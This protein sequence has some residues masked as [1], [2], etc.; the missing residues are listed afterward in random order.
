M[1]SGLY[2]S[3]QYRAVFAQHAMAFFPGASK[4]IASGAVVIDPN[5]P[6]RGQGGLTYSVPAF[7]SIASTTA[8]SVVPTAATDGTRNALA[9]WKDVGTITEREYGVA[10]EQS[11]LLALGS[12]QD[13]NGEIERQTG[14]FWGQECSLSL[15]SVL[16]GAFADAMSGAQFVAGPAVPMGNVTPSDLIGLA[17]VGDQWS[18]FTIWIV[19][20][21]QYGQLLDAGLIKT[22]EAPMFSERLVQNGVIETFLGK[23]IVVDDNIATDGSTYLLKPGAMYLGYQ[24]DPRVEY[25]YDASLGGGTHEFWFRSAYMPHLYGLNYAGAVKP[26]NTTLETGASWTLSQSTTYKLHK[27]VKILFANT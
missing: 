19:P 2:S 1:G 27:A 21:K 25:Q 7:H 16:K 24:S 4:L 14:E 17:C 18:T 9:T 20:S 26:T 10:N 3:V 22:F 6:F 12:D 11:L 5:P 15:I 13:P 23:Q 8:K